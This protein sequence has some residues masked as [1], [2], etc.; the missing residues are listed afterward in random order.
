MDFL[1]LYVPLYISINLEGSA[2]KRGSRMAHFKTG[3]F[4]GAA[5]IA[6]SALVSLNAAHAEPG[7]TFEI[8]AGP[9]D[10]ALNAW[11]VQSGKDLIYQSETV[12]G[13]EVPGFDGEVSSL[14]A[15]EKLLNGSNLKTRSDSSGAILVFAQ[16]QTSDPKPVRP[17]QP[18]RVQ[19]AQLE[20]PAP[21]TS[22]TQEDL[23]EMPRQLDRVQVVGTQIIGAQIDGALPVT[24]LG[25]DQIDG[26]GS[27]DGDDLFRSIPQM[28]DVNFNTATDLVGGVN[29]ARGDVASI[30]LRAIGTGNTL[31]LLNGRRMVNH[32][33][34]Q[35]ENLV[36]VTTVNS[37]AIPVTGV[38]RVEVLLDG[39]AAL[40]GSDAVAGVVNTV[41]KDDFDGLVASFRYGIE[42][43]DSLGEEL[44]FS[45]EA[46]K[47][48]N[49]DRTNLALFGSFTDREAIFA[50]DR[51]FAAN[52]DL[53]DRLPDDWAGDTQFR[54]TSTNTPWGAFI[55]YDPNTGAQVDSPALGREDFH[56]QP[57]TFSGCRIDLPGGICVDDNDSSGNIPERYNRN[58][59]RTI[60]SA[61]TRLNLF[62]TFNHEME[63]GV[64]LFAEAG[65]YSA[66]SDSQREGSANLTADR[67][68]I[69]AENY[70]NP[71]GP[72]G[73]PNRINGIGTPSD[74]YDVEL[75]R[76]RVIDAGPREISVDNTNWRV[77][78]GLRG[79]AYDWNWETAVLI[80]EAET[81][82][83]TTRIS[84]TLFTEALSLTTPQ[85]YNPFNGA[86]L[87]LS[88]SGDGTPS[89]PA[90]FGNF[91]VP[92]SRVSS[93]GL[94]L[95]DFNLSR[96]D[97]FEVPAGPLGVALGVEGRHET[98]SDDRDP[99][100]DGTIQFISPRTGEA[101]S[102][103]MGSSPTLDS[104][105]ERD[106]F[107]A[108][109]EF[110][111]P[112][113]SEDMSIPLVQSLDAQLAVRYEDYDLFGSVTKPKV[114]LAWRPVDPL[115]V[116]AAW[117]E[118]FKAPNLQQQFDRALR[119]SNSR[120][121]YIQCEFEL[122][123]GVIANFSDCSNSEAVV[124]ERQGSTDL[125]PE[126]SEN[127]SAGIV[128]DALFI[129]PEFGELQFTVDYWS[130]EQKE[131]VGIFG[132]ENHLVYDYLL[133]TMG[134]TNPAVVRDTLTQAEQ[135]AYTA[136][137][138]VPAGEIIQINDNYFNFLPR[139]AEGLDFGAYYSIDDT[140]W[141]DF[142]LRANVAQLLTFYQD[143]SPI[144]QT[145]LD[146]QEA[147]Q[148]SSVA[149]L[150][151]VG[152][153]VRQDGLPEWRWSASATWRKG[154]FGAGWFTSFV[155]DVLDTSATND[156]TGDFWVVDSATRHNAYFQYT[157]DN[158]TEAPMRLR[159]GVRNVFDTEPPLADESYGYLGSLHS[160]R[161]RFVYASVRKTF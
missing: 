139:E 91:V 51:S 70:W 33:G 147:G 29:A 60:S 112:L 126:E 25:G 30:N 154:P 102:D 34:T 121:D 56:I 13:I 36:P 73:S 12:H 105:G 77:L 129:P 46:G 5:I 52:E 108:Y 76:Y 125:G 8:P 94:S 35:S 38:R 18:R 100:L 137:G 146:A 111:L 130:I 118:G 120:S 80:S 41:L 15:L 101:T 119:R 22:I 59:D 42:P 39:A 90:T 24:V 153:L 43:E 72:V 110:A 61:V 99:R 14:E 150:G 54:N 27:L 92:V 138:L 20:S 96:P 135:D 158:E 26:V 104:S 97:L 151:G 44:N 28:G 140:A 82:D 114:A 71:F 19:L 133:R 23:E 16:A 53:R 84:N 57:D 132:D 86:G 116:R 89:N 65:W 106:V 32:P 45:F 159:L 1:W 67:T 103:V 157:F 109:A 141:G 128:F 50:S 7:Q 142:S 2:T 87:P 78:G 3:L 155:D 40:Y 143:I 107:S 117:S 161:G 88:A 83:T 49:Q 55:L 93:T 123:T 160:S 64:E 75:R 47:N 115:L 31:V 6:A 156:T 149:T 113:V 66:T 144:E 127:F 98:Y 62:G 74:G 124:S 58:S 152:D 9:L 148:I 21:V 131:V 37:N 81:D 95:F 68:I 134:M 79:E 69:P 48:F 63:T 136:V 10:Q 122:R 17:V 85:A 4:S 11:S 145:I